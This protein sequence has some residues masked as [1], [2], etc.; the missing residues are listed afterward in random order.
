MLNNY[1]LLRQC[2]LHYMRCLLY[3]MHCFSYNMRCLRCYMWYICHYLQYF[4]HYMWY[5]CNRMRSFCNH[6][7]Y[8]NFFFICGAFVV[9]CGSFVMMWSNLPKCTLGRKKGYLVNA[10]LHRGRNISHQLTRLFL[11]V[12]MYLPNLKEKTDQCKCQY[13]QNQ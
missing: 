4:F 1:F 7:Q 5:F 12:G 10:R 11:E 13:S 6:M 2:I 8:F 3:Y 9:A